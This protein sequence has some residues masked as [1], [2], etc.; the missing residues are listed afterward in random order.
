[1]IFDFVCAYVSLVTSLWLG[2]FVKK[3]KMSSS[4]GM[5]KL[6][7]IDAC[8]KSIVKEQKSSFKI[9]VVPHCEVKAPILHQP[10]IPN[11]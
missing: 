11:I 7:R 3:K 10:P 6:I 9:T 2:C 8:Q 4:Q 1:M 5:A